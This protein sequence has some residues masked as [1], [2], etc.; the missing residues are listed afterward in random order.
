MDAKALYKLQIEAT[1]EKLF[2]RLGSKFKSNSWRLLSAW[3][4]AKALHA[5]FH[6][7]LIA[8]L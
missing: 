3:P 5:L 6:L 7:I 8:T 4:L 1:L 2:Y